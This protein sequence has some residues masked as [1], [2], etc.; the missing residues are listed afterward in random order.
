MDNLRVTLV[1][2]SLTWQQSTENCNQISKRLEQH[3]ADSH[4]TNESSKHATDLIVLP[5]MFNSGFTMNPEKVAETMTGATVNWMKQQAQIHNAAVTGSM[6]IR[7]NDKNFNRMVIAF[8]DGTIDYYDKRH[9][10]R[11]ANEHQ[12]YA[13]GTEKKTIIWRGWRIALFVCYDLRFPV[14]CRQVNDVDL[15][16]FIASWPAVRAYPWITLLKA[17][18]IENLCYV[19]GVNRIG[20]DDNNIDY[21]GDSAIYDMKGQPLAELNDRDQLITLELDAQ[22]LADF[23]EKFPAHLDADTFTV[24]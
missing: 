2:T 6:V 11:M 10:F 24:N 13:M 23:R 4:S 21:S 3:L 17:R 15:M 18:A 12:R 20:K 5:E 16:L 19:A 1:Q 8:P 7:D 9:L 22:A 14:W